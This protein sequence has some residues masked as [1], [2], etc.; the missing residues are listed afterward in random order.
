MVTALLA[1]AAYRLWRLLAVDD[2]PPLADARTRLWHAVEARWGPRW[3]DGLECGWCTG[4]WVAFATV[5]AWHAHAGLAHPWLQA[6]AVA[7]LVG[8]LAEWNGD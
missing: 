7:T 2:L 1:L 4:T 3:A 8:L 6:L 5:A